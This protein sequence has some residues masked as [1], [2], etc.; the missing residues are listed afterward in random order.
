MRSLKR[1]SFRY[2]YIYISCNAYYIASLAWHMIRDL[3]DIGRYMDLC[4]IEHEM[5]NI[6]STLALFLGYKE[7]GTVPM[8]MEI[9]KPNGWF[10]GENIEAIKGSCVDVWCVGLI[11]WKNIR[12]RVDQLKCFWSYKEL[13]PNKWAHNPDSKCLYGTIPIKATKNPDFRSIMKH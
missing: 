3:Y 2:L 10:Q 7:V 13:G 12:A 5:R 1:K 6:H 8:N 4:A 9:S 11:M